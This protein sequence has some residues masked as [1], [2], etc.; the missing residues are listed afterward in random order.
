MK[1][2]S[3][4]K[5][6]D[7]AYEVLMC[8]LYDDQYGPVADAYKHS[9]GYDYETKLYQLAKEADISCRS[10]DY[11][12]VNGFDKTPDLLLSKPIAIGQHVVNWVESKALFADEELHEIYFSEQY[13]RYRNRYGPGMVIYWFGFVE[14]L[15][16]G[17]TNRMVT[18]KESPI[19]S[20]NN[21]KVTYCSSPSIMK[22]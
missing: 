8:V 14:P 21:L 17:Y 22:D 13:D 19:Q 9:L 20:R 11:M 10:E 6:K 7:L 12:R 2:T 15:P 5:D 18:V 1:D 3:L 4:I 16:R